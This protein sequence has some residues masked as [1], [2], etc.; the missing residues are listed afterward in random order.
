MET[1]E[2]EI[3]PKL[4]LKKSLNYSI[5]QYKF[6]VRW[7]G[8][9]KRYLHTYSGDLT[10][11]GQTWKDGIDGELAEDANKAYKEAARNVLFWRKKITEYNEKLIDLCSKEEKVNESHG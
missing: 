6:A 9:A 11:S 4:K 3:T 5:K 2:E 1:K 8:D 7:L 10:M